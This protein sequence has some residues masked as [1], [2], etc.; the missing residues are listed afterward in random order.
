MNES[1][2][3]WTLLN[4]LAFLGRCLNFRIASKIGQEITTDF[5]RIDFVMLQAK[6]SR[7][8]LNFRYL[9]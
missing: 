3:Q 6:K 2:V 4:N 7:L 5:G 8:N 9:E 1:L